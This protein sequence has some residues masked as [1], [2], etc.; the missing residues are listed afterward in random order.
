MTLSSIAI[1]AAK[2]HPLPTSTNT[3]TMAN[4][5]APKPLDVMG[6]ADTR[7]ADN[8]ISHLLPTNNYILSSKLL[9]SI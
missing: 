4:S 3:P 5:T 1:L 7:G 9:K 8:A 2:P 6:S